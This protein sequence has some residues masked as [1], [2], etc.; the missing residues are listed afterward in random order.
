M[1]AAANAV[2]ESYSAVTQP[3]PAL[4]IGVGGNAGILLSWAAAGVG[5]ALYTSTNLAASGAWTLA[6]NQPVFANNQWQ[7]ELPAD[8][9]ETRFYRLESK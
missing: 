4:G 1:S 7:I 3:P 5:F 6:T 9:G 8:R 2:F